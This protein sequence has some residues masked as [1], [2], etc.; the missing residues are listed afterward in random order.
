MRHDV[1]IK[2]R[3]REK[4]QEDCTW[5]SKVFRPTLTIPDARDDHTGMR[6]CHMKT[7]RP[8]HILYPEVERMIAVLE[9]MFPGKSEDQRKLYVL[10]TEPQC[11]SIPLR[12]K[13]IVSEMKNGYDSDESTREK[14]NQ[15]LKTQR[16]L[17]RQEMEALQH[18]C[19]ILEKSFVRLTLE[20]GPQRAIKVSMESECDSW[21]AEPLDS[22]T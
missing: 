3:K 16:K 15:V 1:K 18:A 20:M 7:F 6:L 4:E 12:T 8:I 14:H 2:S 17:F 21:M 9:N 19:T 22:V 5:S 11:A 10:E 13:A